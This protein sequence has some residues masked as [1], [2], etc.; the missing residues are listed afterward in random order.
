MAADMKEEALDFSFI[1]PRPRSVRASGERVDSRELSFPLEVVR[2]YGFLFKHFSI[3]PAGRGIAV[4]F[5]ESSRLQPEAYIL[6]AGPSKILLRYGSGRG[7]FYGLSTLLQIVA[8]FHREK[9]TQTL[10]AFLLRDEP[11]LSFRGLLLDVSRGAVPRLE[12]LQ[13]LLL[14]LALLKMNHFTLYI[15]DTLLLDENPEPGLKKDLLTKP[16]LAALLAWA[17]RLGIEVFP[18][19]QG[20]CHLRNLLRRPAWRGLASPR[21][22][23]CLDLGNP[24]A[25]AAM[26]RYL[27]DMVELFPSRLVNIGMDECSALESAEAYGAHLTEMVRFLQS[28]GKEIMVWGDM[29]QQYPQLIPKIPKAV[30]ILN[31]DYFLEKKEDFLVR[32]KPFRRHHLS[33]VLC[34]STWSWAKFVPAGG[35]SLR[36]TAAAC[37]AAAE[38]G[39]EGVLQTSWGDDGNEYLPAGILLALFQ[40]GNLCWSGNAAHPRAFGLWATGQEAPE[41]FSVFTFLGRVDEPLTYTHRYYLYEDPL[42]APFSAQGEPRQVIARYYKAADYLKKKN[43]IAGPYGDYLAFV[44]SLYQLI[45]DKVVFSSSLSSQ[46]T[47]GQIPEIRAAARQLVQQLQELKERYSRLWLKEYKAEGLFNNLSKLGHVQERLRYLEQLA[48]HPRGGEELLAAWQRY[49]PAAQYP[50]RDFNQIFNQ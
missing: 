21:S 30:R 7:Q 48:A 8:F 5:E 17:R 24:Q 33:Q 3:S 31:W 50:A 37:A 36:N 23:D 29:F 14:R 9:K 41:L 22:D 19:L 2:K 43:K 18:S 27:A 15:E 4:Q 16:E 10:P 13:Q 44:R 32:L 12:S 49:A 40:T 34:P 35:K 1:Y 42:F 46:L 45:A 47:A 38:A 28:K 20:L 26:Q 6:E 39:A 11:Q 25:L